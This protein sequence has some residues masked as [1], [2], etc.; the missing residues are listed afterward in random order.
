MLRTSYNPRNHELLSFHDKLQDFEDGTSSPRIYLEHCL[1][2]IDELE[3]KIKAFAAINLPGARLAADAS[4]TRYKDGRRLSLVD[5]MPFGVKDLYETI[6]MPTQMNSPKYKGWQ[7]HRDSAHV[8]ALR[9]G[10]AVILGK[11]TTTEFGAGAP[12][13]TRNPFDTSKTAGGSSSGSSAAVGARMLPVA[14]GSQVRG[15]IVRP[16]GYCA[17]YALKPSF[18]ALNRGGAHAMAPSQSVLGMHAGTLEDCWRTAFFISDQA[19][20]DPG[21]PG[22]IGKPILGQ[23]E[24]SNC[25]IRLDSAGWEDTTDATKAAFEA[26]IGEL[27]DSGVEVVSRKDDPTIESF[28]NLLLKIPNLLPGLLGFESKWPMADYESSSPGVLG[29]KMQRMLESGLAMSNDKYRELLVVR[30]EIRASQKALRGRADGFLLLC[31]QDPAPDY[32]EIGN[33]VYGD[34]SSTLGAPA[35]AIPA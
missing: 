35:V 21:T 28:E 5:G 19:G 9:Q 16:A 32:P 12:P 6:D 7:S 3:E 4:T 15:S 23:G 14:S 2:V 1:E 11:T 24:K 18:G 30:A 34:V 25:L 33:T 31:S 13:P 17:N 22:I 8:F 20:G 10:G 29:E 26:Y 27:V